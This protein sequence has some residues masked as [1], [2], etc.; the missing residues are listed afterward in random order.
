MNAVSE[1][2]STSRSESHLLDSLI[3]I[4][5]AVAAGTFGLIGGATVWLGTA[6]LLL[7]GGEN[8]GQHMSLLSVFLPGYGISW[9]GSAAGFAWGFL[10]GA[11][12][13]A[14]LYWS[15]ARVLRRHFAGPLGRPSPL[16][17]LEAPLFLISRNALGVALGLVAGLQL[18]LTTAWLVARGTANYSEHAALLVN[19][20]P[21]YSVSLTGALLGSAQ[22]FAYA[23]LWSQL[24]GG[25]YN[26]V[27]KQRSR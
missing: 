5:M 9:S 6:T 27:A 26:L 8:I 22:M 3:R 23:F 17:A 14:L 25:I 4:N 24:F 16:A 18:F 1:P 15:Y 20:L 7:S 2:L 10:I 13:G 12:G 21:G 19:Y 11:A